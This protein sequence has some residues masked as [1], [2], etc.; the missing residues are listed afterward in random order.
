MKPPPRT[1]K[2][3]DRNLMPDPA[4]NTSGRLTCKW[5]KPEQ[6]KLLETLR[7]LA[8]SSGSRGDIDYTFLRKQVPNRSIEEVQAVV[9]SLKNKMITSVSLKL[10]K[11]RLEEEKTRKPIDVWSHMASSLAGTVEEQI[12]GAFSQMMIVA[13]TEPC[14]LKNCDP[15]Q[16]HRPPTDQDRPVGRTIP[17]RPVPA[18]PVQGKPPGTNRTRPVVVLKALSPTIGQAKRPPGQSRVVKVPHST[19][20]PPQHKPSTT[21]VS[22]PA[23]PSNQPG[24]AEIPAASPTAPKPET[25]AS[26]QITLSPG[27][28]AVVDTPSVSS[29]KTTQQHP[30]T[31]TPA[32]TTSTSASTVKSTVSHTPF[33]PAVTS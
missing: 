7:R 31:S 20:P 30:S 23:A 19:V 24:A 8:K 2:I 6:K 9:E 16:V 21:S 3:P 1:R 17:F 5:R 27:S 15:P 32:P 10:R 22:S 4:K 13:S 12:T 33:S 28:A 25:P 14:T 29:I 11:K 18:T 26:G